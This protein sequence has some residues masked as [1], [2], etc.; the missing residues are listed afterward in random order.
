MNQIWNSFDFSEAKIKY[1]DASEN[2]F[3]EIPNRDPIKL[4]NFVVSNEDDLLRPGAELNFSFGLVEYVKNQI[5]EMLY[6]QFKEFRLPMEVD[7]PGLN[8][9]KMHVILNNL[10]PENVHMG[11]AEA[12][13]CA[14]LILSNLS[15]KFD[16]DITVEKFYIQQSGRVEID[17]T[18][19]E[20]IL[21]LHFVD[22]PEKKLKYPKILFNLVDLNIPVDNLDINLQLDYV[23]TMVSDF[24]VS[25]IKE[26]LISQITEFATGFVSSEGS[27][28]VNDII[29]QNYP[30]SI[31]V[32]NNEIML[33]LLLTQMIEV[34]GD[35]LIL[36][37]D[38][39]SSL[40]TDEAQ[41]RA[42]PNEMWFTEEDS[43]GLVMGIS[44]EV[45]RSIMVSFF[46]KINNNKF[47]VNS[48]GVSGEINTN[49]S[50]DSFVIAP[51]GMSLKNLLFDGKLDY[52]G[53]TVEM[54]FHL[55][56]GLDLN[57]FDFHNDKVIF[58]ITNVDLHEF[59]F[60]SNSEFVKA[61]GPYIQALIQAF[62]QFFHNYT[63]PIPEIELP[64]N[65][66]LDAAKF[67]YEG[68][69]TVLKVDSHKHED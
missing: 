62:G 52:S 53:N 65:I 24:I 29:K 13:N 31:S 4:E 12:E 68:G 56:T 28:T 66:H 61:F 15:V 17:A 59:H 6:E 1:V 41:E 67:R 51:S 44:Q 47:S 32:Y 57:T 55:N 54:K 26:G 19:K 14:V 18:I 3:P 23:P 10:N 36:R 7:I 21:K 9:S 63:L 60:D 22:E 8:L 25:Y 50:N 49:V 20:I 40:N 5:V 2:K 33:S 42:V 46:S 45:V 39:L 38:A 58:S 69:F 64:Y 34:K 27:A 35:R 48:K 43:E 37:V 30:S 11:L 16:S